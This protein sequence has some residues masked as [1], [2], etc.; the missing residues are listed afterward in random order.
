MPEIEDLLK[1]SGKAFAVERLLR[2]LGDDYDKT[3]P[4]KVVSKRNWYGRCVWECDNDVCDDQ[5]V[6]MEWDDDP[7]PASD[8]NETGGHPNP[9]LIS[10]TAQ[11]GPALHTAK[12]VQFHMVANTDAVGKRHG[13]ISGTTGEIS[14]DLTTI[15]VVDFRTGKE[16]VYATHQTDDIRNDRDERLT[17]D[18]IRAVAKVKSGQMKANEA[19]R[20]HLGCTIEDLIRSHLV[21]FWAEE[22][23]KKG[24]ILEWGEWWERVVEAGL[25]RD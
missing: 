2:A 7:L 4:A 25:R 16:T 15:R 14:Y 20:A 12:T 21:V 9:Q 10:Q 23:R 13:R 24:R 3:T 11:E 17:H 8:Q 6:T 5:T 22:S 19:Q 18:F 1:K